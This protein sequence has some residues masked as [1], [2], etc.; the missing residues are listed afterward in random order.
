MRADRQLAAETQ[1]EIAYDSDCIE[2]S[3]P[4]HSRNDNRT[5][6]RSPLAPTNGN[7]RW[8]YLDCVLIPK[9]TAAANEGQKK[10][11]K[12]ADA[13]TTTLL[14][15]TSAKASKQSSI[16]QFVGRKRT[17]T[18]TG[19]AFSPTHV[20]RIDSVLDTESDAVSGAEPASKRPRRS[21]TRHSYVAAAVEEEDELSDAPSAAKHSK[22]SRTKS[23]RAVDSDFEEE[24][25]ADT[26]DEVSEDESEHVSED[27]SP[28]DQSMDEDED[29]DEEEVVKP[30]G[31]RLKASSP[32][33]SSSK[34]SAVPKAPA[35]TAKK[36]S[37]TD[38]RRLLTRPK[39]QG[40]GL[41]SSLPPLS[42]V[43][44]IFLAIT[45]R[46]LSL[47]FSTAVD[48]L[49]SRPLRVA[50][51]CSGTESP[52]L[53]LEMV[54]DAL[55]DLGLDT[56]NI[57][58][59]FSAEIV[60]YKQAYI[61]R[62]FAPPVIFRD[63]CEFPE[64]FQSDAPTATTA[65]GSEVPV[66]TQCD[67]LIAG[68]SC[69]D[70]S[71]LNNKTKGIDEGGESGKTWEG[72]L[73]YCK[74]CRPAIIIFENV[75]GAD[76]AQMLQHY[77]EIDYDCRGVL[78]DSKDYYMP[79][80]RQRGYMVCF[81]K[82]R[83]GG[84][85]AVAGMGAQWQD[86]MENFKRCAS[87]PV[88]SFLLP[89][90]QISGRQQIREDVREVDWSQCEITQMQY[91]QTQKLGNARPFTHWQE[92]GIMVPPDNGTRPWFLKQV[93][94][95]WDTI[96]CSIL[97]KSLPKNGM[98]DAR[99]KTRIWDLSQNIYRFTDT[100]SFGITGCITPSGMFFISDANRVL[101]PEESLKLQ[102]IPLKKISFTTETP[103]ELQDLAGNAMTSTVVGSALL[104]ALVVGHE[105]IDTDA[106]AP[107]VPVREQGTRSTLMHSPDSAEVVSHTH[108]P[109][110]AAT[111]FDVAAMLRDAQKSARKCYCEG[112]YGECERPLQQCVDC[113]HSTCTLCGGSPLHNYR[114]DPN[115]ERLSPSTFEQQLKSQLPLRVIFS[116][117]S[118]MAALTS[119]NKTVQ[120][121]LQ[122]VTQAAAGIF[123]FSCVRRTH[124]WVASY[125]APRARLDL[126]IEG[127]YAEWRLF[128]LPAKDLACDAKLR[129]ML[130]QPVAKAT[131]ATSLLGV[132]WLW[133]VPCERTNLATLSAA[134]KHVSTWW[135]RNGLPE[136]SAHTQP[137]RLNV[138]VGKAATA[139]E[140]S[141]DGT[142]KY[143]PNCGTAS[144]S[145]YQK[146]T[147]AEERPV[148]LFQ[149]PTRTGDP[150]KDTFV[151][152]HSKDVLDYDEV[153]SII[154]RV[155]APWRPWTT[156]SAA[157][158]ISFEAT[159]QEAPSIVLQAHN[160]AL[161]T[162]SLAQ[163]S[164]L[165]CGSSCDSALLL[166]SCNADS[167]DHNPDAMQLDADGETANLANDRRFLE[168][169]AWVFEAMRR[170][171]SDQEWRT[172]AHEKV[173]A[174]CGSCAP[175]KPHLK[176]KLTGGQLVPY[177]DPTGA[178]AYERAIK[179][180]PQPLVL[181]LGAHD[182]SQLIQ[183]GVNINSL[184]HRALA[185]SDQ[186]HVPETELSW[187]LDVGHH[188]TQASY[189]FPAFE[190]LATRC[191]PFD[192]DLEMSVTLFPKQQ[193]SLAWMR[194][195]ESGKG[196]K[197]MIEEAVEATL[198]VHNWRVEVRAR[199]PVYVRGGICADHPGF[200]K[201]ITSLALIQAQRLESTPAEI[202]RDLEDR[203]ASSTEKGLIASTATVIVCPTTLMKQWHAEIEEKLGHLK[204]ILTVNTTAHL[205]RY[206]MADFENATIILVNRAMLGSDSYAERLAAFAA[207]PGPAN[208]S[209]RSLTQWLHFAKS[210]VPKHLQVLKKDGVKGLRLYVKAKYQEDVG[211]DDFRAYVPS[212]R[213]KGAAYI[214]ANL[215][216][217]SK[218]KSE[219]LIAPP[220]LDV[221]E[222]EK[223][224]FEMFYFNRIIIDEFHQLDPKEYAATTALHA[225]KR[226]ALSATPEMADPYDIARMSR[227]LGVK[228]RI[229]SDERGVM[230]QKNVNKLR[231][232]M[233]DFE[234]FDAMRQT[235]S[236]SMHARIREIDQLFLD[237]FVRRNIMDFAELKYEDNLVPVTLDVDHRAMYTE[238]SQHL[239]SSNMRIRKSN[240][241]K[242]TDRE[243]RL[244]T[245]IGISVKAEEALS[246]SAAFF[247]HADLAAAIAVRAQESKDLL[248]NLQ[249]A[250]V[251]A[252]RKTPELFRTWIETRI[253]DKTLGDEATIL[254]VK[255]LI[256]QAV[257]SLG[258][259]IKPKAGQKRSF[260]DLEQ[261]DDDNAVPKQT[262]K[263]NYL[264]S[265]VNGLC[266][267]LVTSNRSHRYLQNVQRL[268]QAATGMTND[269][270]GPGPCDSV[271]CHNSPRPGEVAVSAFCGHT[272]CKDCYK[273][274]EQHS[275]QCPAIGCMSAM[276]PHHLLWASKMGDLNRTSHSP[277]GAKINAAMDILDAV[278][279]RKDKAILFMQFEQ[280]VGEVQKALQKR[281]IP[282]IVVKDVNSAGE[283]IDQFRNSDNEHTVIVL[284]SSDETAAG[285]NLQV[286]NHV[287][288]LSPLLKNDQYEYESTMAQAIGR[289]RRHGQNK[290]IHVYRI[291]ALDTIDVDILEHR[292]RRVNA[293]TEQGAPAIT[294]PAAAAARQLAEADDVH[295]EVHD[296]KAERTQLVKE[297]GHFSL[298]PHSWLVRG[299]EEAETGEA[300]KVKRRN[301]VMGWEDFSSLVKFSGAYTEDDE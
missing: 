233:T 131:I 151:F 49:K 87:S 31:K 62:N 76:W 283:K 142:Y 69:V 18:A 239:N 296:E 194:K 40:K 255:H 193:I 52:L 177:E 265:V 294:P 43:N 284:N 181:H 235:P 9:H 112:S 260:S 273:H 210:R 102:G 63:I 128:A 111:H 298:R 47:G 91:R 146:V 22:G 51:M 274:V 50:T 206:S 213:V 74:A 171:L 215:K 155:K 247:E 123:T 58:H 277:Y 89:N 77:R 86:L 187:K 163:N 115:K 154:A 196:A 100:S 2:V 101:M 71:K 240:K 183:F 5:A 176:W 291:V 199:A 231:K 226:W 139:M 85:V 8:R 217:K 118:E 35:K 201:T 211:S 114:Q 57:E 34:A 82:R 246:R 238:L 10:S 150:A 32:K 144:D 258:K 153:R 93:E 121:Y 172:I 182:N 138:E 119:S 282:A 209:G 70:Y 220:T 28:S 132:T 271:D 158:Q 3:T 81:N 189:T 185:M 225:D 188:R 278:R 135:A 61:E 17:K 67:I 48:H 55:I 248:R 98:Y 25:G 285:S 33:A 164:R 11:R 127:S 169:N 103:A 94:R 79:H 73:A 107:S 161:E 275:K 68:T 192:R 180:R 130:E 293:L 72:A 105:L 244:H 83:A 286:A 221:S 254:E 117:D 259:S 140:A 36:A 257:P 148:Y 97:R 252:N 160:A 15:R 219:T 122:V 249:S 222:I 75:C 38:M 212:K 245:A 165:G 143:L 224:L 263:K 29:E 190:M 126:V 54:H 295:D 56:I 175:A 23:R 237:T 242:A 243:D 137:D 116:G 289:V 90:D 280:Q 156:K 7:V 203:Q 202:K 108:E 152:S 53:A 230:K 262:G 133:R 64:A 197:F 253:G 264:T 168:D 236:S 266:D 214:A 292:E 216:G 92:S 250:V 269:G 95:V 276:L 44:D 170:Q 141:I 145:L 60:P 19:E 6:R 106:E 218:T 234:R 12:K 88:S 229:G 200:G 272:V 99:F 184:A 270:D 14:P 26:A 84:K 65:Y 287:I 251:K 41:E 30:K 16:L 281:H 39:G 134:G 205:S 195:Q 300:D 162:R 46:A 110:A 13:H 20:V 268:H 241:A 297:G 80:T 267:R 136:F 159:W 27:N 186:V 279:K 290:H 299:D 149:D 129:S 59:I 204:G 191:S 113:S 78:V 42:A 1:E 24:E 179:S 66:P 104:A 208:S 223:P 4:Q 125:V 21:A 167:H 124:R 261:E 173:A 147:I 109:D 178:A 198:P 120:P 45:E 157:A 301:R 228:L 96:D 207:I 174:D 37:T 227:L 166:V 256:H 288:F 232:D